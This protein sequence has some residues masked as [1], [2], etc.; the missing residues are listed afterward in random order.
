MPR[1]GDESS[2][3]PCKGTI[4]WHDGKGANVA[5]TGTRAIDTV[6]ASDTAT[7]SE[8]TLER[9]PLETLR[10]YREEL[11]VEESSVSYWRRLVQARLDLMLAERLPVDSDAD[12]SLL[13]HLCAVLTDDTT[14][15]R[16]QAMLR[17]APSDE[18]P[19]PDLIELWHA[20][21]DNGGDGDLRVL[22]RLADAERAL[23]TYRK[24]LHRR[25]DAAT[26]ELVA[27]YA[28]DPSR[29]LT[30]LP[31]RRTTAGLATA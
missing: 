24:A 18:A 26:R 11:L 4:R 31:A 23:S 30:A 5:G 27:R 8:P 13:S 16:R 28:Q 21:L 20:G 12:T 3:T 1:P 14:A 25:L 19:L 9:L 2:R 15:A 17:I 22:R 7:A 29:C 6:D 10:A